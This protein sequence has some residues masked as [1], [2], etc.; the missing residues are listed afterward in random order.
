MQQRGLSQ[1]RACALLGLAR[2]TARYLNR[3]G[4]A[5]GELVE[6]IRSLAKKHP[7]FG[8]RRVGALLRRDGQP[9]NHKRLYRLWRKE[10]LALPRPKKKKRAARPKQERPLPATRPDQVWTVDFLEDRTGKGQ[11]LR[12][13]TITDEFTRES[14]AIEIAPRMPALAV[15]AT[16]ARVIAERG[17]APLYLRSDNGPEFIAGALRGFLHQQGVATAYIEPGSP[18]QNG[19]AESFHSRFRDEFLNAEVFLSVVDAQVRTRI[20]RRWYNEERPHSS[21]GYQTPREFAANWRK[22]QTEEAGA[23]KHLGT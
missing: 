20:W 9:V 8:Y 23:N 5:Q 7:R 10:G 15:A 1:R 21:L 4:Q 14:L 6:R 2:S 12:L 22:A 18:W 17:A 11:K 16:L 19:Y 3:S 13:L